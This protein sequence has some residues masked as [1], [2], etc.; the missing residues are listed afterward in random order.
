LESQGLLTSKWRKQKRNK[1]FYK[2][3]VAG[4]QILEQL[5]AEWRSMDSSINC[6]R[7]SLTGESR[8]TD[9]RDQSLDGKDVSGG[10]HSWSGDCCR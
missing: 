6:C 10:R 7:K 1:R 5:L 4:K 3:T 9:N 8:P 2:L